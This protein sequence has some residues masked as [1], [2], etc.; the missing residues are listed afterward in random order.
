FG[1]SAHSFSRSAG[2]A[3]KRFWNTTSLNDYG[4]MLD[5]D[6]LPIAG[7]EVLTREM[8]LDEAFLIGLRRT[9]GFDIWRVAAELGIEYPREWFD[10]VCEFEDAGWVQFDGKFLKLTSSG[11]LL[12]GAVT[13]ELLW[14]TLLSTSAA[15]P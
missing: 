3:M 13:E 4:D 12:A 1:V 15:T 7:E 8:R 9:C 10:R 6:R 5:A 11:W 14:P 2:P